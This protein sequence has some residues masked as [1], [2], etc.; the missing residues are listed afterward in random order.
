MQEEK[1]GVSPSRPNLQQAKYGCFLVLPLKFDTEAVRIQQLEAD[2]QEQPMTT[3]DLN[4]NI[5]AVSYTHLSH[6]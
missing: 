3:M 6:A 5:K 2:F 4:E 1:A